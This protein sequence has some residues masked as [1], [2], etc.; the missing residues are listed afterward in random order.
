MPNDKRLLGATIDNLIDIVDALVRRVE[1]VEALQTT[2]TTNPDTPIAPLTRAQ[3][4]LQPWV[5][6]EQDAKLIQQALANGSAKPRYDTLELPEYKP[7]AELASLQAENAEMAR[8]QGVLKQALDDAVIRAAGLEE[9]NAT[10]RTLVRDLAAGLEPFAE[11][12]NS[13]APHLADEAFQFNMPTETLSY[14]RPW[15]AAAALLQRAN[16]AAGKEGG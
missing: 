14:A 10:L 13:I 12:G 11:W 16:E 15:K 8:K 7:E 4:S 3:E 9:K 5:L 2:V 1:A 6:S